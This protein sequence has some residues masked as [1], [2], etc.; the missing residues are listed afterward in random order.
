MDEAP[1]SRVSLMLLL[2][3]VTFGT[4]TLPAAEQK[5]PSILFVVENSFLT[6]LAFVTDSKLTSLPDDLDLKQ[7]SARYLS[8]HHRYTLFSGGRVSGSVEAAEDLVEVEDCDRLSVKAVV[9]VDGKVADSGTALASNAP[10]RD[11]DYT[12][13]PTNDVEAAALNGLAAQVYAE[14]GVPAA[15][16]AKA[17][18]SNLTAIE[19]RAGA[20]LV[21]SFVLEHQA[22]PED[23]PVVEAVFI[24]A[25]R[26]AKGAFAAG[27][28]WFHSGSEASVEKQK[29]VDVIDVTGS[30]FPD[31]VTDIG[32]YESNDYHV[33]RKTAGK[34][35]EIYKSQAVGC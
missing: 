6:P 32:Y 17:K 18:P 20:V 12:R 5:N 4:G 2:S 25:E 21:G 13:R 19:G 33:Y 3:I 31:V 8:G 7:F 1:M 29:F 35:G 27:Y 14:H 10:L 28:S 30:G 26:N 16:A 23:D 22:K 11:L 34:W 15:R 9:T 24:I